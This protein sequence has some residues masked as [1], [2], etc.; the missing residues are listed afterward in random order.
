[1]SN[2]GGNLRRSLSALPTAPQMAPTVLRLPDEPDR[3]WFR[4]S[5]EIPPRARLLWPDRVVRSTNDTVGELVQLRSLH[6]AGFPTILRKLCIVGSRLTRLRFWGCRSWSRGARPNAAP[7]LASTASSRRFRSPDASA[8]FTAN[9]YS[10][11]LSSP[12]V[13]L[14][15]STKVAISSATA[16]SV[17]SI[18]GSICRTRTKSCPNFAPRN[19]RIVLRS[20]FATLPSDFATTNPNS[21]KLRNFES[22]G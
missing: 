14:Q 10:S 18:K 1:M 19:S 17:C 8:I 21:T 9:K 11:F 7:I 20:A 4:P 6:R 16:H 22:N 3:V 12:F 5:L 2:V 15:I 13:S